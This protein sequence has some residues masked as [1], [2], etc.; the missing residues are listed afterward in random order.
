MEHRLVEN[1]WLMSDFSGTLKSF[2]NRFITNDAIYRYVVIQI[3]LPFRMIMQ[4]I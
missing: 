4:V 2:F 1:N 3:A